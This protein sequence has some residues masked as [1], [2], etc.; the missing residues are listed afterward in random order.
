M[1][2]VVIASQD[3]PGPDDTYEFEYTGEK[4][5]QRQDAVGEFI[6]AYADVN[7]D[8]AWIKEVD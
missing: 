2:Y 1:K 5:E 3:I 7:V 6:A 8:N 4:Y